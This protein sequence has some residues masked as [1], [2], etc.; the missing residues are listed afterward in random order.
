MLLTTNL[1]KKFTFLMLI[2][3]LSILSACDNTGDLLDLV[4]DPPGRETIDTSRLGLNNFF[5]DPEFGNIPQQYAEIQNTLGI[6]S[7]RIL[8][9]WVNEVQPTPNSAPNFSFFDDIVNLS[10]IHI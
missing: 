8:M 3:C 10:L 7:L 5:V 1:I 2:S 4:I 6:N 9:A